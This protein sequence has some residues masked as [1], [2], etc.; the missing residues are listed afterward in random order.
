[1]EL[2]KH[3][4]ITQYMGVPVCFCDPESPW[5]RGASENINRLLRQ[6]FPKKYSQEQFNLVSNDLNDRLRTYQN[7]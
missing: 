2:A 3:Q 5:Q 7:K 6:Y 1:M 4:R